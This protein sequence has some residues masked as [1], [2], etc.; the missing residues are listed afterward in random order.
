MPGAK[1]FQ[2]ACL[3]LKGGDKRDELRSTGTG[4]GRREQGRS[5]FPIWQQPREATTPLVN[6]TNP[7]NQSAAPVAF[8]PLLTLFGF[9]QKPADEQHGGQSRQQHIS[10]TA[11]ASFRSRS[12]STISPRRTWQ[13]HARKRSLYASA[14]K[15]SL[16]RQ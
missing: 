14:L 10:T 3:S 11:R 4:N 16:G 1:Q 8:T 2:G 7:Y 9:A 15:F 13:S 12:S 6:K 5:Q